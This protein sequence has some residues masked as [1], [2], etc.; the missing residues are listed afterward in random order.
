MKF[1]PIDRWMEALSFDELVEYGLENTTNVVNGMPWSFE[2]KRA[3][4]PAGVPGYPVTH[5]NDD[6]YLV[7]TPDGTVR[8]ERGKLLIVGDNTGPQHPRV[9]DPD[10]FD[11]WSAI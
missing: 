11:G 3:D 4:H 9:C 7:L 1:R 2:Y 6:C 5:E 10:V 8:F